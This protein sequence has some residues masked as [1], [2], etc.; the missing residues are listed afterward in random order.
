MSQK[1]LI[2]GGVGYVCSVLVPKLLESGYDVKVLDLYIDG[3][4]V[5]DSVKNHPH[6]KEIKGICEIETYWKKLCR[7]MISLYT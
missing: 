2:T 3:E 4:H 7:D 1:V 5:F 6:L